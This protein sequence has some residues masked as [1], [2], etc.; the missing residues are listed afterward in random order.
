MLVCRA[1]AARCCCAR[2][3]KTTWGPS[4]QIW[5]TGLR[6]VVHDGDRCPAG[7]GSEGSRQTCGARA[8]DEDVAA[9]VRRVLLGH[10]WGHGAGSWCGAPGGCADIGCEST[11][12]RCRTVWHARRVRPWMRT[13]HSWHTPM[14][15][16][17][18]RGSPV[19]E[20]RV[21]PGVCCA[22]AA[23]TLVPAGTCSG[24]PFTTMCTR[25]GVLEAVMVCSGLQSVQGHRAWGRS[26]G[27]PLRSG[28]PA[29]AR[30]PGAVVTPSPSCPHGQP[31]VR[32]FGVRANQRQ[33]VRRGGAKAGPGCGWR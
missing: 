20:V 8:D 16:S 18:A 7:R 6:V 33:A 22:S 9:L 1:S 12:P 15:H 17:G 24:V 28:P 2:A 3:G 10:G 27:C 31:Q 29:T 30:W 4:R 21:V 14:P 5:P 19:M 13:L 23:A 25:A 26:P 32:V 11:C